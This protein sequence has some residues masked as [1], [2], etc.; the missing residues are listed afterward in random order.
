MTSLEYHL[1]SIDRLAR[2]RPGVAFFDL[3]RTLIA[4]YSILAL[5]RETIRHA[6]RGGELGRGDPS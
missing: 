1:D 4:G 2:G 5:A 6:A 3:D